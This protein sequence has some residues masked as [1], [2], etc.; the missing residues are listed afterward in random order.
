MDQ[1]NDAL[2]QNTILFGELAYHAALDIVIA[3]A[4]RELLVFDQ[5]LARGGYA[6]IKRAELIRTF[7]AKSRTNRLTVIV[8]DASYFMQTC[9]RLLGL[10]ET[11]GHSMTLY[12]TNEEAK[13][14]KDCF[15][16]ADQSHYIRRFHIDQAR[17][18]YALN[19]VD[20][21]ANLNMR[22][23]ELLQA[24]SHTISPSSLGL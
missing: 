4:E 16:V 7:L 24:T 11:Y 13:V 17:F 8:H 23:D 9:P 18:K 14:A 12:Q 15:V 1:R 6:S 20:T 2:A 10:L 21:S 5:D 22:F 19:D 3:Q